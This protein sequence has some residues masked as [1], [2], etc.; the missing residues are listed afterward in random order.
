MLNLINKAK[1][2]IRDPL[3]EGKGAT[4]FNRIDLRFDLSGFLFFIEN[5]AKKW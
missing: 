4:C 5:E 3:L 1:E 2:H